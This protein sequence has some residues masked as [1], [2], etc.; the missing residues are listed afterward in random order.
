MSTGI[1]A[2]WTRPSTHQPNLA[3]PWCPWALRERAAACFGQALD[4]VTLLEEESP[5][6]CTEG[7]TLLG[8]ALDPTTIRLG[9]GL[10]LAP[11]LVR[12]LVLAHELAHTVQLARGGSD[13]EQALEAE[14]WQ[15]AVAVLAGERFE[16]CGAASRP[17]DVRAF[18]AANMAPAKGYYDRFHREPTGRRRSV[19]VDDAILFSATA[20]ALFS[21]LRASCRRGDTVVIVAHSS[22]HGVGLRLVAG[23]PYG[24]NIENV[25]RIMG[26]ISRPAN[27]RAAALASLARDARLSPAAATALVNDIIAVRGLG[28]AAVHFRGC[29][30]A[31]WE[32]T[33]LTF[34]E[35]FA[36]GLVTGL[37]LPSA[38]APMPAPTVVRGSAQ[39]VV[40]TFRRA[41][42]AGP[43]PGS[44]V[45]GP[46]GDRFCFQYRIDR[47]HH[48]IS[49]SG[50]LAESTDATSAW[51][52]R[53]LPA[54]RPAYTS[55]T[56]PIHALLNA[57]V[58][59]FPFENGTPAGDY[60]S[61]IGDS[62]TA[63]I[64]P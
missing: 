19:V 61:Q 56:F 44:A 2:T 32:S 3:S 8:R 5:G 12:A 28:L 43:R 13:S 64:F 51:I 52:R 47:V 35:L 16:I 57:G 18:V 53:H 38:Y 36:C 22:E 37:K 63:A 50:V 58:L 41:V 7:T 40:R 29:N 27:A 23:N 55:G 4:G 49:F 62:Q 46:A 59:I 42:A 24:L 14:A 6:S 60:T 45:D 1:S 30:L 10:R 39:G 9:A 54:P 25:N 17:L 33:P 34:K 21:T 15:A 26:V 31:A 20:A 48:R 11:P